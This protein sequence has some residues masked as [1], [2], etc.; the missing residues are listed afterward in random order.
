MRWGRVFLLTILFMMAAALVRLRRGHAFCSTTNIARTNTTNQ[1]A[2]TD[3]SCG[4]TNI[5]GVIYTSYLCDRTMHG[6]KRRL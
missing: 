4:T 1:S 2:V 3:P 5:M 6:C